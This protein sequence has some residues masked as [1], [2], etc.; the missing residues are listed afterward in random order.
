M[1]KTFLQLSKEQTDPFKALFYFELS[2]LDASDYDKA[3][4][5]MTEGQREYYDCCNIR[6]KFEAELLKGAHHYINGLE[7]DTLQNPFANRQIFA[8]NNEP[9]RDDFLTDWSKKS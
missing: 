8:N 1:E 6:I 9:K 4:A 3:T 2:R 7:N 5:L